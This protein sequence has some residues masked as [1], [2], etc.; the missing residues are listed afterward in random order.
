MVLPALAGRRWS[1]FSR[2]PPRRDSSGNAANHDH[3]TWC[4]AGL[5]AVTQPS[6]DTLLARGDSLLAQ[7]QD[8]AESRRQLEREK[9]RLAKAVSQAEAKAIQAEADL[10]QWLAQWT[11]AIR[12]LGL[13]GDSSPVAV[14]EVVAQT[15]ELNVQLKEAAAF[16]ERIEGIGRDAAR[17]RQ[18]AERLLLSVD[19]GQLPANDRLEEALEGL[20]GRLRRA[21][22]DQKNLDLLQSQRTS[23]SRSGSRPTPR[24][25]P[26]VPS[27]RCSA[28]M[29]VAKVRKSCP[30]PK[31]PRPRCCGC[32]RSA[33]PATANSWNLPPARRLRP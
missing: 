26:C 28:R 15:A 2:I 8:A 20:L 25:R 12:P 14:N 33:R 21:M 9:N 22:V 4:P 6:L 18:D 10:T 7:I 31:P 32:G 1:D 5:Q 19:P 24:S 13:P 16:V 17:F 3:S 30:P 29:P 11:A 23:R 27:W